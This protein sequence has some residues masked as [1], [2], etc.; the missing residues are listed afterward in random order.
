MSGCASGHRVAQ[1]V[2][3]NGQELGLYRRAAARGVG[4]V[5][6]GTDNVHDFIVVAR[7]LHERL[8]RILTV[9][10]HSQV[11]ERICR[12]PRRIRLRGRDRSVLE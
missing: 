7:L 5:H 8:D 9:H 1:H 4:A 11:A 3:Q 10:M 6:C 2:V 12:P